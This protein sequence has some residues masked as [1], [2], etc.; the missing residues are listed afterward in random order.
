MLKVSQ[1]SVFSLYKDQYH[2]KN[3]FPVR[4]HKMLHRYVLHYYPTRIHNLSRVLHCYP[5]KIH[6][7]SR[8]L[9]CYPTTY[10]KYFTATHNLWKLLH[11]YSQ[12]LL[13]TSLSLITHRNNLSITHNLWEVLQ[14]Y[15]PMESNTRPNRQYQPQKKYQLFLPPNH[16]QDLNKERQ[17]HKIP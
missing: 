11:Y 8:V 9:H 3:P 16:Q 5:T 10:G 14:C 4:H 12:L 7:L 1:L 2:E 6:N 17:S 13:S 15:S